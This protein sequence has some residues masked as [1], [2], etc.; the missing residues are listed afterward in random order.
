MPAVIVL[1][2]VALYCAGQAVVALTQPATIA[3]VVGLDVSVPHARS[4]VMTFYGGF[5]AGMAAL[6][7]LAVVRRP[8][9]EGA[10]A[11]LALA[12]TGAALARLWTV[13]VFPLGTLTAATLLVAEVVFAV[14]GWYGWLA[15]VR[16]TNRATV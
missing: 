12:L 4:E 6:F 3:G 9:R 1:V 14:L 5:Y 13:A 16:E 10:L 2:L 8:V 11:F 7:A 15:H